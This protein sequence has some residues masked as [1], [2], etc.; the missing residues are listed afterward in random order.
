VLRSGP[1]I[2]VL[3]FLLVSAASGRSG[4]TAA[5]VVWGW[6]TSDAADQRVADHQADAG[7]SGGGVGMMDSFDSLG[8]I[9][10]PMLGAASS[11]RFRGFLRGRRQS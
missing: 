5:L 7:R 10:G 9:L 8:R 2:N 11:L 6:E 4:M 1:V 3:G